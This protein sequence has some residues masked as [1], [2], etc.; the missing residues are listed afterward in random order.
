LTTYLRPISWQVME[1]ETL[2]GHLTHKRAKKIEK[3]TNSRSWMWRS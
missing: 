2:S 1:I 3:K